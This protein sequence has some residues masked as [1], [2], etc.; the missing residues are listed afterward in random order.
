MS[1]LPGTRLGV[2]EVVAKLGEGGMGEVYRA[3]DTKLD[4]DVALKILPESFASDPERLMRF[5]REAKTLA[6][7]NHPNIAAIYGIED[8]STGSG[9]VA[10]V[11][12]LVEGEDLSERIAR[13]A[14]PL[15]EALPIAKQIAEALAAAH[16]QGIIH[17]DLKPANIKIRDDGTIKVLDFGLAK[18]VGQDPRTSG[19]QYLVNSPT[20]T[21]PAMTMRGVILGTAAYMS[22]E[23]AKGKVVDKRSDIWAFGCV[24]YEMLTGTRAF[25]GETLTDV[26]A[27]VVRADP[28]WTRLPAGTPFAVRRVLMRCLR[29]DVGTRLRDVGDVAIDL[30]EIDSGTAAPMPPRGSPVPRAMF[31]V[32]ASV[33]AIGAAGAGWFGSRS[34]VS[35]AAAPVSYQR[36]T[37]QR[38]SVH[39]ARFDTAGREVLYSAAWDGGD[40]ALFSTLVGSNEMQTSSLP[41]ADVLS[42]SKQGELLVLSKTPGA[43]WKRPFGQTGTLL[44]SSRGGAAR[45]LAEN[46]LLAE[47]MPEGDQVAAVRR[48]GTEWLIERPLGTVVR[49]TPNIVNGLRVSPDGQWLA[50]AEKAIGLGNTWSIVFIDGAGNAR[51]F[52][53]GVAGDYLD[54]AWAPHV[55]EIWF[56]G[57]QGADPEWQA[58]DT[59]GRSRSLLRAPMPLRIMDVAADGRVLAERSNTRYGVMGLAPGES[60]E[61]DY[62]WL[63]STELDAV[64]GDGRTLLLT[65]FGEGV[66]FTNWVV[67]LRSVERPGVAR[68]T[69]GQAFGLSPDGKWA[70]TM[71]QGSSPN[72]VLV[73]IG[74][75]APV[76]LPPGDIVNF[77]TGSVTPDG[78]HVVFAGSEKGTGA[79]YF[80]QAITA[81]RP[82][83]IT[84]ADR[85]GNFSNDLGTRPVS[86]DGKTLAVVDRQHRLVLYGIGGSGNSQETIVPRISA[87]SILRWSLDGCCVYLTDGALVPTIRKV[88][89]AT[90]HSTVVRRLDAIDPVGLVMIYAIQI[91]D[92]DRVYYYTFQRVLSDLFIVEGVR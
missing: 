65:E 88:N 25:A 68:L 73:P 76:T 29:K 90:G 67:G 40:V 61:R 43:Q 27:A 91:A 12:E 31:W 36:V 82:E 87:L 86:P 19:P 84:P 5:E 35:P 80:R 11:M 55:H 50:V 62:S 63:D 8:P 77:V 20:I 81:G 92:D 53:A 41:P 79:R 47:W 38:G 74:A 10:L 2:Y 64:S 59:N 4:R 9:Q 78:A 56:N 51:R 54:V 3:R 66:G 58:M 32:T 49:R 69:G 60:R 1:L 24:V 6:S 23:Q 42:V 70:L 37:F 39:S 7:L 89:V 28:D 26:L 21:S 16:E 15:D 72:L 22:P 34:F 75:G 85:A 18:A 48:E 57:Y 71:R 45:T 14:I 83:P 52:D 44:R 17:R 30:A 13:G 33:I 46:V